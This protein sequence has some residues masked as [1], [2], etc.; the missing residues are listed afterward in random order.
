[1]V[2][3]LSCFNKATVRMVVLGRSAAKANRVAL[4]GNARSTALGT[5]VA[6]V[7][8]AIPDFHERA[9]SR[10]VRRW[11]PKVVLVA[12]SLHSPWE[13]E[14]APNAW[15]DLVARGFGASLPLQLSIVAAASRVACDVG[16]PLINACY[17]DAVNVV[18]YGLKQPAT[19][20]I[21]NA[22]I[23]ESFCRGKTEPAADRLKV[24]AHHGHLGGWLA[25]RR[26]RNQPRIWWRD[27][28]QNALRWRPDFVAGSAQKVGEELNQVTA[29]TAVAVLVS[30]LSGETMR[31]SIP[32]VGGL[33]GGYPFLLQQGK[34]QMQ[35][36]RGVSLAEAIAHNQTGERLDGLQLSSSV[37]F[38]GEVRHRLA[39]HH[40]SFAD[41]FAFPDWE[42]ARRDMLRLRDRLRRLRASNS[43]RAS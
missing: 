42:K 5:R 14:L 21:G 35:L 26:E 13:G 18:L 4:I 25:G 37:K 40:Y 33:P 29:A 15:T 38:V 12:A 1:M 8:A 41:G 2:Y 7:P 11:K 19:C 24:I 17:P 16:T 43:G 30:L 10:V 9:L 32:G 36:P 3:A 31:A 23:I 27:K 22:A 20:G 39:E 34:F 28:E 6:C